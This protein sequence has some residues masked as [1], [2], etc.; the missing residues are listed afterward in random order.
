M[1]SFM[2]VIC[3]MKTPQIPGQGVPGLGRLSPGRDSLVGNS[4]CPWDLGAQTWHGTTQLSEPTRGSSPGPH[5]RD[6]LV[7]VLG[8]GPFPEIWGWL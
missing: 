2:A 3:R 5:P 1:G 8:A 6:V 7:T 4:P